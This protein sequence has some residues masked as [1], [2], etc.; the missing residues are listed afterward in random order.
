MQTKFLLFFCII[1]FNCYAQVSVTEVYKRFSDHIFSSAIQLNDSVII[2]QFEVS[3][4]GWIFFQHSLNNRKRFKL[5]NTIETSCWKDFNI[6]F[7]K[8]NNIYYYIYPLNRYQ[9][10]V[11]VSYD[12]A[13]NY[14]KWRSEIVTK[15]IQKAIAE[16]YKKWNNYIISVEYRLP[17]KEEWEYAAKGGLDP[18]KYPYGMY[19]PFSKK[20]L[21]GNQNKLSKTQFKEFE[22]AIRSKLKEGVK[23]GELPS[24]I[25]PMEFNINENFYDSKGELFEYQKD[26][27]PLKSVYYYYP[28]QYGIYNMIGNVSEMISER[29]IAK[30][31]SFNNNL[32]DI[33]I[34]EDYNYKVP[35]ATIGFRCIGIIHIKSKENRLEIS[36]KEKIEL[37]LNYELVNNYLLKLEMNPQE[38]PST[39]YK[40]DFTKYVENEKDKDWVRGAR[41]MLEDYYQH[42]KLFPIDWIPREALEKAE[43]ERMAQSVDTLTIEAV[44]AL[45]HKPFLKVK[46]QLLELHLNY[47]L[48]NAYMV[49][50]PFAVVPPI[51]LILCQK[52][53][54]HCA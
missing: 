49:D 13:I 11:G 38:I 20:Y 51:S 42:F 15:N 36:K 28:N 46:K 31:G 53:T 6:P 45:N 10:V 7:V 37:D 40:L 3:N 39:K 23:S 12:Q 14:C 25:Q 35:S 26:F 9:P 48:V 50:T 1:S 17:T 34:T 52:F 32:D 33:S 2:D 18:V 8:E 4:I 44:C 30:G 29:D 21:Q 41:L 19:R 43:R 5:F 27:F 22:S 54:R 16:K 47:H 24:S